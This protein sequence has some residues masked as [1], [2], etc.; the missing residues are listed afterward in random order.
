MRVVS[1]QPSAG[2]FPHSPLTEASF[3][4]AYLDEADREEREV[5]GVMIVEFADAIA[6]HLGR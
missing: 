6:K 2:D 1:L 3:F 5:A 4:S